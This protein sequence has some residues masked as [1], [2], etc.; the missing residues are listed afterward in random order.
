MNKRSRGMSLLEMAVAGVLLAVLAGVCLKFFVAVAA[1]RRS[2]AER[3]TA[4]REA[5]NLMERLAA[6]PWKEL[7][8]EKLDELK[9][10]P[11]AAA[12]LGEAELKIETTQTADA[13]AGKRITLRLSWPDTSGAATNAVQLTCWRYEPPP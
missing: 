5:T 7:T 13:P 1:Q 9:L 12:V 8:P 6:R 3:Q 10:S 4:L 2:L 11:V